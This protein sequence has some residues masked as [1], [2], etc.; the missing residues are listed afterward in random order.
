MT[1]LQGGR[2]GINSTAPI[3]ALDIRGSV[4][5]LGNLTVACNLIVNGTTTTLNTATYQ[6]EKVEIISYTQGPA[7][8]V[9]Q[10]NAENIMMLYDDSNIVLAVTDGRKVGINTLFPNCDLDVFG[11]VGFSQSIN[12]ISSNE[13]SYLSGVTSHIQIQINT[14]SNIFENR[15]QQLDTNIKNNIDVQLLILNSNLILTSNIITCNLQLTSNN[16]EKRITQLETNIKNNIDLQLLEL[17]S[18][19]QNTSNIITSN[20]KFTSNNIINIINA[21]STDTL[22]IGDHNKFIIDNI[23]DNNL[24]V[25]GTLTASEIVILEFDEVYGANGMIINT[26][27]NTYINN[28]TSNYVKNNYNQ[29]QWI[30]KNNDIYYNNGNVGIGTS[31]PANTLH[32]QGGVYVTGVVTEGY[33]DERLKT[34]THTIDKPLN[35]INS[36][37]GFYYKPNNLANQ[38][39]FENDKEEI[40]LSAQ[41][42]NKVLPELVSLAPFDSSNISLDKDKPIFIS[43]TGENYLTILYERLAPL[44]VESIKELQNQIKDNKIE[45]NM[46]KQEIAHLKDRN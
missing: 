19:L 17:N 7:L 5:I 36:L 11:S 2:V 35:I 30:S 33:S 10:L 34:I 1:I 13:V 24:T 21:I 14:N 20:L 22:P 8:T 37:K 31:T 39:G 38:Y 15:I 46:L 9:N 40:G 6:T 16:F 25:T 28:V 3:N 12:G 18:N 43:K 41:D 42:V 26:D 29:S 45:I 44:F 27:L 4:D 23:Y 32:V